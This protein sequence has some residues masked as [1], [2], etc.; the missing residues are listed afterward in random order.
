MSIRKTIL[1]SGPLGHVI[2]HLRP[3]DRKELFATRGHDSPARVTD[4]IMRYCAPFGTLF[5]HDDEPVAAM[6]FFP[7]WPGVVTV[8]AFGSHRWD[9]VVRAMTRHVI[10][11][12]VPDLLNKGVHR[13]ECRTLSERQDSERW[14]TALG[15]HVEGRLEEF[16][17]NRE[18]FTLYAWSDRDT[19]HRGHVDFH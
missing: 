13:A 15:A 3:L 11:E 16:G 1:A 4:E 17:R 5:W 19:G 6:G 12:V 8:W 14:L 7:M 9:Y 10:N 18:D 2:T